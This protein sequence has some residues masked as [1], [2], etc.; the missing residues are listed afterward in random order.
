MR[1]KQKKFLCFEKKNLK[2]AA[3]KKLIFQNRQFSK[4]FRE[5][6]LDWSLG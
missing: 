2:M 5:N 6:F 4:K 1:M 3:K